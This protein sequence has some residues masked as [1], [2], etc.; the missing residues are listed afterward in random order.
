MRALAP[1]C[2]APR[3]LLPAARRHSSR[4]PT[5]A[6][7]APEPTP[8]RERRL[9]YPSGEERVIRCATCL[10]AAQHHRR[11]ATTFSGPWPFAL[12]RLAHASR[13]DTRPTRLGGC[14][15]ARA[16]AALQAPL[17]RGRSPSPTPLS[18]HPPRL[19]QL[20][21]RLAAR[22]LPAHSQPRQLRSRGWLPAP[23]A[24]PQ[25]KQPAPPPHRPTRCC[26]TLRRARRPLRTS[27]RTMTLKAT[28]RCFRC[29]RAWTLARRRQTSHKSWAS[30]RGR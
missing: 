25:Q 19:R 20:S 23:S 12:W 2:A 15:R 8:R 3:S 26:A 10:R 30:A 27:S 18:L 1:R 7:A 24:A 11:D 16:S 21:R 9:R 29:A 28:R 14:A 5:S 17:P 4:C 13:T 6:A 22:H